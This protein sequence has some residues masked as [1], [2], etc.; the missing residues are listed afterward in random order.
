MAR[1]QTVPPRNRGWIPGMVKD[2]SFLQDCLWGLPNVLLNTVDDCTGGKEAG[3][4]GLISSSS[5]KRECI[6]TPGPRALISNT[7][8]TVPLTGGYEVA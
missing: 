5:G 8:T 3:A 2:F 7:G 4:W 1:T 6:C